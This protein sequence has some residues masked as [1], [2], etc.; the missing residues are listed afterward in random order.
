[1]LTQ[2]LRMLE[3]NGLVIRDY[4]PTVPPEVHYSLSEK[5]C[6]LREFLNQFETLAR[7][8]EF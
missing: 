6:E 1:M 3:E 5:G 7:K 8:W 2:R 4:K